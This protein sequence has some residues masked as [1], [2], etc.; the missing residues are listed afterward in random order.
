MHKYLGKHRCSVDMLTTIDVTSCDNAKR[1]GWVLS[2]FDNYCS[3]LAA[4]SFSSQSLF[5]RHRH[6]CPLNG[7]LQERM[8][9]GLY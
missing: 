9:L 5:S 8:H 7:S 2:S 4:I 6:L 1:G 3:F